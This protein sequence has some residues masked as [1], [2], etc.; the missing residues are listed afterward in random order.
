MVRKKENKVT[1]HYLYNR[2]RKIKERTVGPRAL[3]Y[4][5]YGARGISMFPEWITDSAAFIAYCESIGASPELQIDRIDNNGN[6]EPGN[7]RFVSV[8]ENANNKG[9]SRKYVLN[10]EEFSCT[11]LAEIY[12]I[13]RSVLHARLSGGW[14]VE[15]AISTPVQ[16]YTNQF[17]IS[18]H[19]LYKKYRNIIARCY[20]TTHPD[21][22][23]Y[24]GRGITVCDEWRG[25]PKQFISDLE[26]LG[27]TLGTK[28]SLDRIDNDGPYAPWNCRLASPHEQANNR[29]SNHIIEIF[30]ESMS[31]AQAVKRFGQGKVTHDRAWQRIM[32]EG[33]DIEKAITTPA[34][35]SPRK[36][37]Y[38]IPYG[39][40]VY[41]FKDLVSLFGVVTYHQAYNRFKYKGWDVIRAVSTPYVEKEVKPRDLFKPRKNPVTIPITKHPLYKVLV[42]LKSI[43]NNP[44][45]PSYP[46]FGAKGI[47]LDANWAVN[48]IAFVQY[49][50]NL[51]WTPENKLNVSSIDKTKDFCPGNLLLVSRE[52]VARRGSKSLLITVFGE[53]LNFKDAVDKYGNGK[54]SY[55]QAYQRIKAGWDLEKAVTIGFNE[56]QAKGTIVI[57]HNGIEYN[58]KSL[59]RYFGVAKYHTVLRRIKKGWSIIDAASTP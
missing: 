28:L 9:N 31:L 40:K 24:G 25:S 33:W 11:Q 49:V 30:G 23:S 10:G 54:V 56:Q 42:R 17:S 45:H 43:C 51:G 5:N 14:D 16:V 52:D 8:K 27:W 59:T 53:T 22:P 32:K 13:K 58:I 47:K 7:I 48:P 6:Y 57:L 39:G 44:N 12:G 26:E 2:W 46:Q 50:E 36:T 3:L 37:D 1:D 20:C 29:R 55:T 19:P 18:K 15:R 35:T 41:S 4:K 34:N 38:S 21:Y